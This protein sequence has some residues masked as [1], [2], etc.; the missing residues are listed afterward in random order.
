MY[1][2]Y[3]YV[4]FAEFSEER[5]RSNRRGISNK[6]MCSRDIEGHKE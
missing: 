5:I 3:L 4:S 6:R 1:H 2:R